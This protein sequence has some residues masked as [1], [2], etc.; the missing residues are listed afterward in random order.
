MDRLVI[1]LTPLVWHV[2]VPTASIECRRGR[3]P[4]GVTRPVQ[5]ARQ[6]ARSP[7]SAWLITTTR[8]AATH[9]HGCPTRPVPLSDELAES[10]SSTH[11]VPDDEAVGRRSC[12]QS[13][14]RRPPWARVR[15]CPPETSRWRR[16]RC[17]TVWPTGG[18]SPTDGTPT[19]ST[20]NA[21]RSSR[22]A[23]IP[24]YGSAPCNES[25]WRG[26]EHAIRRRRLRTTGR[27][28]R[29]SGA[30]YRTGHTSP[31]V[32]DIHVIAGGPCRASGSAQTSVDTGAD[33]FHAA[34]AVV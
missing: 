11:P 30:R 31:L 1:E 18:R 14:T 6:A 5:R 16:C 25:G 7:G 19:S 34:A 27:V 8:R 13:R 3:R 32:N 15:R 2:P 4:D 33:C 23:K 21:C 17:P 10:M 12:A 29:S 24:Q 9:P 28:Y 22:T 20:R 26:G